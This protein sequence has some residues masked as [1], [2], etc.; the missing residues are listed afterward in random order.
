[1]ERFAFW[2]ILSFML[3]VIGLLYVPSILGQEGKKGLHDTQSSDQVPCIEEKALSAVAQPKTIGV[4]VLAH[5]AHHGH[6][7]KGSGHVHGEQPPEEIPSW[8]ASVL[9]AVKPLKDTY[10]LEVAFGMADPETIKEAVHKLEEKGVSVVIVV[11]LFISSHSPI[12]GN[13]R[14]ILGLQ[15]ELPYTTDVKSLPRLESKLRFSMTEAL[16]DSPL[17]AEILLERSREL[18]TNPAKETVILVGHGPNDENENKLWLDDMQKL[19]AYVREKGGFKEVKVATWRSD[20]PKEIK[21]KAIY[22][23]RTMVR[24]SGEDG[25]VIIIPHLISSGGVENEI[26]EALKGLTYIFNGK[27]LL[28]HENITRWIEK[29]VE[30]DIQGCLE[31][32][33]ALPEDADAISK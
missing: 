10:P 17:V 8:N 1:M 14:Y 33:R 5:G 4:L 12:I 7:E 25:R 15:K 13:S 27:T 11:P 21:D 29:Q 19:A 18:S 22:E 20:A 3:L 32:S 26:V 31:G 2:N 16:N 30:E 9:K 6:G 23:L 28:P 24:A